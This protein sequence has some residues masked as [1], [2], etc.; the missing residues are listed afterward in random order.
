[1]CVIINNTGMH[2]PVLLTSGRLVLY[3]FREWAFT[4]TGCTTPPLI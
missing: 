4:T 1:M 2:Y 3:G